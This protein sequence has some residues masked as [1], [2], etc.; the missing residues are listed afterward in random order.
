MSV[1][2]IMLVAGEASGDQHGAELVHAFKKLNSN[3]TFYGVGG[4]NMR[5]AEV[6]I[7]VDCAQLAVMGFGDVVKHLPQLIKIFNQLKKSLAKNPPDLLILI[8]YPGFNLRLAKVAKQLGIKVLFYISPQVWAWRQGRVKKIAKVV[9]HM[10]VIFPFEVAF[11]KNQNVPVTYVGHPLTHVVKP[12]LSVET[13]KQ[14]FGIL[15]NASVIGLLPGSREREIQRLLPTMLQAAEKIKTAL[16]NAQFILPVASTITPAM[17][18]PYLAAS[19]INIILVENQ[20]YDAI[21]TCDAVIVSSGTATLE[22]ALLLK[23]MVI[24][25]KVPTLAAMMLKHLVKIKNIGLCNVVAEKRI[26]PEL[27]QDDVTPDKLSTEILRMLTDEVYRNNMLE[28]L[29]KVRD[30]LGVLNGSENVAKL[31]LEMLKG[32]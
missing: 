30:K 17:L 13:A 26:V 29:K 28:E 23:P 20:T 24:V 5:A 27:L 16:P 32:S 8:D 25:Y 2:K 10:A 14:Q 31:A 18:Q 22:T 21:N 12:S 1:K 11:Y 7:Q 6:D 3:V 19:Q 9:D 15:K 4:R